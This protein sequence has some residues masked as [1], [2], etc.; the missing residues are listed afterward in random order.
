MCAVNSR[1]LYRLSY[2][3]I[4][5]LSRVDLNHDLR[6]QRPAL[7]PVELRLSSGR[8]IRTSNFSVQSRAFYRFELSLNLIN[9]MG[10]R[11]D[12]NQQP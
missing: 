6:I 12:S 11:L 10:E 7:L 9:Q 8:R 1:A 4:A 2:M 5:R 3:G